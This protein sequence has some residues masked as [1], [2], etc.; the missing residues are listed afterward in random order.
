MNTSAT[1]S[2]GRRITSETKYGDLER[3]EKRTSLRRSNQDTQHGQ[4]VLCHSDNLGVSEGHKTASEPEL[5][6][7]SQYSGGPCASGNGIEVIRDDDFRDSLTS[8]VLRTCGHGRDN[9]PEAQTGQ[10]RL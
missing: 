8:H 1:V 10:T 6:E 7:E 5:K 4:V 9:P 3:K 2:K